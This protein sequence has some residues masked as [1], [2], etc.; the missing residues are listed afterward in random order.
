MADPESSL[1]AAAWT[2]RIT[3]TFGPAELSISEI[4]QRLG[5]GSAASFN[6]AFKRSHQMSL[7]AYRLR[8]ASG[9]TMRPASG[10]FR[11]GHPV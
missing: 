6:R 5:Y 11:I 8:V 4:C 10:V 2:S 3:V 7:T 9:W 1:V